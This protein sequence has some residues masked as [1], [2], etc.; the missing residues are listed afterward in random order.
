MLIV[1]TDVVSQLGG[2]SVLDVLVKICF[3]NYCIRGR[4]YIFFLCW[5]S[6]FFMWIWPFFLLFLGNLTFKVLKFSS[7]QREQQIKKK[8]STPLKYYKHATQKSS[9]LKV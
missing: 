6:T 8:K 9:C 2:Y 1:V 5:G 7:H 4:I 3:T